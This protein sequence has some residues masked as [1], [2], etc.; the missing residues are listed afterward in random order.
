MAKDGNRPFTQGNT[1]TVNELMETCP[2][3]GMFREMQTKTT[4]RSYYTPTRTAQA[5]KPSPIKCGQDGE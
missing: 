3:S 2:T 4:V 5:K 1:G